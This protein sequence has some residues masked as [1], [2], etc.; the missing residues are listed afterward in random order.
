MDDSFVRAAAHNL[1]VEEVDCITPSE[2]LGHYTVFLNGI[3]V[4]IHRYPSLLC[5]GVRALR[6]SGRLHPHVSI[7]LND[8]QKS[9]QIGC[10]GGRIVRLYIVVREGSL[11]SR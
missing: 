2:F 6:R 9:V 3:L 7:S 5:R 1:G 4:G 10:D 11:Q 8:R